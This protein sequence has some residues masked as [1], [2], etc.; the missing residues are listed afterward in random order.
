M[1]D[2]SFAIQLEHLVVTGLGA[3]TSMLAIY[4]FGIRPKI[5]E[6]EKNVAEQTAFQT[7]TV[8]KFKAL[9]DRLSTHSSGENTELKK[10]SDQI[11]RFVRDARED[12][13][14]I[15]EEVGEIKE[16][17]TEVHGEVRH[18]EGQLNVHLSSSNNGMNI[19]A[20]PRPLSQRHH[21]KRKRT[22]TRDF[23]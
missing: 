8:I 10:I 17:V 11:E 20:S 2:A 18:V 4:R 16:L 9:E 6:N 15:Y 5:K 13:R 19:S 23:G 3:I 1:A 22:R 21:R 12:R 7:E 14:A